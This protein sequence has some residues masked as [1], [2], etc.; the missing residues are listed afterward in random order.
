MNLKENCNIVQDLLPNYIERLTREETN[1]FIKDHLKECNEC[2]I[3]LEDMEEDL[4]F[5]NSKKAKKDVK[6]IKKYSKKLKMLKIILL[7]ISILIVVFLGFTVRKMIIIKDLNEKV[8]KYVNMD[9]RYE[10]IINDSNSS[11][12]IVEYYTKG[13]NAVLFLNSMPNKSTG[14]KRTLTNYFKGEKTNTYIES[15]GNKI[16]ILNSNGLP[17]KIMIVTLDYGNNLWNLF[18]T[19]LSTS[20]KS[21]EYK[22]KECYIL[23]ISNYS[24]IYI[25]KDTG[26]R[27]KA[28]E[29]I[30]VD[31]NGN[32]SVMMIEYYYEFGTVTDDIFIEPD[33]NEYKI[34][35]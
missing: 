2:K 17:S 1:N 20:I 18:Q 35:K 13:D 11:T 14:E 10:K 34:Q 27:I 16:A 31:Q 19:A 9:N 24:E 26:L 32:E 15:D 23:K 22:G 21:I 12:S 25:E 30:V 7:I 33:I 29:G 8:S 28:K 6:Y 3:I 4:K 5:D